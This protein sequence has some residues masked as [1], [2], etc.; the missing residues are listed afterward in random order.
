MI[1]TLPPAPSSSATNPALYPLFDRNYG[2]MKKKPDAP[3]DANGGMGTLVQVYPAGTLPAQ[4]RP[5]GLYV[6]SSAG[7]TETWATGTEPV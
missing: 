7:W 2:F 3:G 1:V 4:T 6:L 5:A